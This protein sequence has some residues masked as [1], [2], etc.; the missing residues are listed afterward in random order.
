[1]IGFDRLAFILLKIA[2][3]RSSAWKSRHASTGFGDSLRRLESL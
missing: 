2:E 3:N 1:V